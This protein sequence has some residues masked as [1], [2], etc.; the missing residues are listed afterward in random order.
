MEGGVAMNLRSARTVAL[1]ILVAAAIGATAPA[2]AQGNQF[3]P[4]WITQ[5]LAFRSP[6]RVTITGK[7]T[8]IAHH[9]QLHIAC[10]VTGE[11]PISNGFSSEEPGTDETTS[12]SATGCRERSGGAPPCT[13]GQWQVTATGLP[14]PSHLALG[15]YPDVWDVTEGV[16]LDLAC[17]SNAVS[18]HYEGLIRA[19]LGENVP[20]NVLL[21]KGNSEE[22]SGEAQIHGALSMTDP[23]RTSITAGIFCV[24]FCH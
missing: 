14:W 8:F 6:D 9:G 13:Q 12:F 11:D 22:L 20:P 7:L 10:N 19:T 5:G 23:E 24:E 16:R 17:T 3:V 4:R 18:F 15:T 1:S 2:A 21:F